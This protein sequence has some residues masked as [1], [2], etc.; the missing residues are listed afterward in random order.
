VLSAGNLQIRRRLK[1]IATS[2]KGDGDEEKSDEKDDEKK[3]KLALESFYNE[4]C[5]GMVEIYDDKSPEHVFKKEAKNVKVRGRRLCAAC[6]TQC[7]H[8]SVV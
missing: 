2:S 4:N 7:V 3:Q 6:L 1:K 8:T 5:V